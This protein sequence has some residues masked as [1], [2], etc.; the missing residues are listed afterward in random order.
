LE[1]HVVYTF[2]IIEN[3]T[4]VLEDLGKLYVYGFRIID[5]I[6]SNES[7]YLIIPP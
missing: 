5:L 3:L 7:K 1:N 4:Q 6:R 2:A